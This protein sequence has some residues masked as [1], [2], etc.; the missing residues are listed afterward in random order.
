MSLSLRQWLGSL[1]RDYPCRGPQRWVTLWEKLI[2]FY[3]KRKIQHEKFQCIFMSFEAMNILWFLR[4]PQGKI[5]LGSV[6][7]LWNHF[8]VYLYPS[9]PDDIWRKFNHIQLIFIAFQCQVGCE[10]TLQI[11]ILFVRAI[12]IKSI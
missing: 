2:F 10:T 8:L 6:K 7:K 11:I 3:Y 9:P 5:W 4:T 1:I 12:L